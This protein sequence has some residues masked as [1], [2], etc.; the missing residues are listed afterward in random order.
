MGHVREP[1]STMS[2]QLL[3]FAF[4]PPPLSAARPL[5]TSP[6]NFEYYAAAREAPGS[7][8]HCSGAYIPATAET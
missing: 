4:R 1:H 8:K 5:D 2:R 7:H 3:P 6:H